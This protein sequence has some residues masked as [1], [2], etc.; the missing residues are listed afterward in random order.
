[1][2]GDCRGSHGDGGTDAGHVSWRPE[3]ISELRVNRTVR[4]L[5]RVFNPSTLRSSRLPRATHNKTLSHK[6]LTKWAGEH[7]GASLTTNISR[8][9]GP[10]DFSSHLF[11]AT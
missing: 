6:E 4:V 8:R 2:R 10:N 9:K 3:A 11:M 5:R 7:T 1:M